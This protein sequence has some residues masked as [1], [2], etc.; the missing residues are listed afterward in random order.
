M[1]STSSVINIR[2]QRKT[3]KR[4]R[5]LRSLQ[6]FW[7][8]LLISSLAGGLIWA[9]F[10]PKWTIKQSQQVEIQ[11][12]QYLTTTA[13]KDIIE[14][15]VSESVV[16]LT[17][18]KIQSILQNQAPIAQAT[19]SR[20][21]YPPRVTIAVAERKPVA[22]TVPNPNTVDPL[23]KGYLDAQGIWMSQE[24]Y[25]SDHALPTP[26]LKVVGYRPQYRLQW[27]QIYPQLQALPL[28]IQ[29]INW[30]DP[31]NLIL[32]TELGQV[33]LGGNIETLPK[34]L[35][36]LAKLRNLPQELPPREMRYINLKD[37]DFILIELV[38]ESNN[39]N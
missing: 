26:S 4:Q 24:H 31:A 10:L 5:Q 1:T 23:E 6:T 3:L 16:T 37:P 18:E 29:E 12:N 25:R 11:G 35:A 13:I 33:H 21:L 32:E 8:S 15:A 7:R 9:S 14:E 17:P 28:S 22:V 19:V 2:D 36:L 34:Q 38:P 30:E 27:A 39:N 20:D